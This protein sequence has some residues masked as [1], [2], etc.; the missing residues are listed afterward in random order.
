MQKGEKDSP[1]E[2]PFAM[3]QSLKGYKET[4]WS[5][6][7]PVLLCGKEM[8]RREGSGSLDRIPDDQTVEVHAENHLGLARK[9][10]VESRGH[11]PPGHA[12][13]IEWKWIFLQVRA[14]SVRPDHRTHLGR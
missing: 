12:S 8:K 9:S 4:T 13:N 11:I 10:E 7:D 14:G 3:W 2:S 5:R 6:K 1:A